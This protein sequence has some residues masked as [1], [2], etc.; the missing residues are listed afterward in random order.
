MDLRKAI[1]ETLSHTDFLLYR[2]CVHIITHRREKVEPFA[3]FT[4]RPADLPAPSPRQPQ[5]ALAEDGRLFGFIDRIEALWVN[6]QKEGRTTPPVFD[7]SALLLE[8]AASL[9]PIELAALYRVDP[10]TQAFFFER[11]TPSSLSDDLQAEGQAQIEH[12][13][14]ALTL[15]RCRPTVVSSHLLRRDYPRIHSVLLTPLVTLHQVL[16]M[17]LFALERQAAD[18]SHTELTVLSIFASQ[19]A[20]AWENAQ[21]AL[22]QHPSQAL[23]TEE[24]PS[25]RALPTVIAQMSQSH[26][27]QSH[28]PGRALTAHN[29]TAKEPQIIPFRQLQ[30]EG[31]P[32]AKGH[33]HGPLDLSPEKQPALHA[34]VED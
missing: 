10:D 12:G 24:P 5:R 29:G 28:D 33:A 23:T 6:L 22:T 2:D 3:P 25:Q 32:L 26:D 20:L 18:I 11:S 8:E 1:L 27:S 7:L 30:E 13:A 14:F 17:E 15:K 21:Y 19:I 4:H 34:P 9:I 16:G 31:M